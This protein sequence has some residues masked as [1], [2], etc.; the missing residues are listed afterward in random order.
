MINKMSE[1]ELLLKNVNEIKIICFNILY[2]HSDELELSINEVFRI[3]G[4]Y[5]GVSRVYIF[6][7]YNNDLFCKNTFEWCA[8][9]IKPEKQNLQTIS[10][11]DDLADSWYDNFDE[12]GNLF[13][14]NIFDLPK[15]HIA[16]LEPQ[17]I[18]ALL[19]CF[20]KVDDKIVGY[21][22]VDDCVGDCVWNEEKIE[23]LELISRLVSTYLI[24]ERKDKEIEQSV[25]LI[26]GLLENTDDLVFLIDK[27]TRELTYL[28]GRGKELYLKD[29]FVEECYNIYKSKKST[30]RLVILSYKER[31]NG[32]IRI[33]ART[34][35]SQL[36]VQLEVSEFKWETDEVISFTASNVN[37][38][39]EIN[40]KL[41]RTI[42]HAKKA[43]S[44]KAEYLVKMSHELRTPMNVIVGITDLV[45]AGE[46]KNKDYANDLGSLIDSANLLIELING[47]LD[48]ISA[49]EEL[50]E[51]DKEPSQDK[52]IDALIKS[53]KLEYLEVNERV[54]ELSTTWG[55]IKESEKIDRF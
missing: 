26:N 7:N 14:P 2:N 46:N 32:I 35:V 55:L 21:M 22:G 48:E 42:D 11:K 27:N 8:S 12:N 51:D 13:C 50:I 31:A 44:K 47:S 24:K 15:E 53:K 34:Q 4:L 52:R 54:G 49:T 10:Y 6:E 20:I 41:I 9:G 29:N 45:L 1:K 36:V 40:E 25:E 38:I 23:T 19:Q 30:K 43:N 28:N 5:F 16:V 17:G 33:L 18:V 37:E 3:V 39:Y